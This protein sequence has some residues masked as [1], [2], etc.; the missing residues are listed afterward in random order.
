MKLRIKAVTDTGR[1]RDHNEDTILVGDDIL[2]EGSMDITVNLEHGSRYFAAI[3]DG[4]GGHSA[5]EVAS[6]MVLE[7]M[8]ER[9]EHLEL[10]LADDELARRIEEWAQETHS[11]ILQEGNRVPERKSMSTTLV[12]V[13]FYNASAYYFNVGDS[14][15]YRLRDGYLAQM[16]RDHSLRQFT[17]DARVP[18]HLI[19]NSFGGGDKV[20]VDFARVSKN[21]FD[22]GFCFYVVT[23]CRICLEMTRSKGL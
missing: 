3:A 7:L 16:T 17:G 8:H 1:V 4:M 12:G 6:K 5:G 19:V 2:R 9:M 11:R 22:G 21:L 18:S 23:G 13:L 20:F 14:R 10:G 15:L